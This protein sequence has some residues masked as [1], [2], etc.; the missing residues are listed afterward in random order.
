MLLTIC[1]TF[2]FTLTFPNPQPIST[3]TDTYLIIEEFHL[4]LRRIANHT[5]ST[6]SISPHLLIRLSS[7][8]CTNPSSSAPNSS[9]CIPAHQIFA[10]MI[11]TRG[12]ARASG[13][14]LAV[15]RANTAL[16]GTASVAPKTAAFFN[17]TNASCR[18][19][20]KATVSSN[21]GMNPWGQ[22]DVS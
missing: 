7:Q 18:N 13:R 19:P 5:P 8:F 15:K 10:S 20:R 17:A 3:R 11:F 16:F 14:A 21:H 2:N 9:H 4:L 12:I 6:T 1:P 22:L